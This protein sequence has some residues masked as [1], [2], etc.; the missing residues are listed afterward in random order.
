MPGPTELVPRPRSNA[1]RLVGF[2]TAAATSPNN[3]NY[4]TI[5]SPPDARNNSLVVKPES[6]RINWGNDPRIE[7]VVDE[8]DKITVVPIMMRGNLYP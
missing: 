3:N 2:L 5:A 7:E 6:T 4:T 8:W 1:V